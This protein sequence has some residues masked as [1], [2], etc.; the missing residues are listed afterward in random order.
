[1]NT[2][3]NKRDHLKN[4]S[5]VTTPHIVAS[6]VTLKANSEVSIDKS[7]KSFFSHIV[8]LLLPFSMIY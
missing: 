7:A 6:N 8:L 1:M 3:S 4:I 5:S 2:G